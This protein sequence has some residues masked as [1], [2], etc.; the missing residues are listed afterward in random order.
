MGW[1]HNFRFPQGF[2]GVTMAYGGRRGGGSYRSCGG[3]FKPGIPD[4][5]DF[6]PMQR[7]RFPSFLL[8]DVAVSSIT[9]DIVSAGGSG[10][11]T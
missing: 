8:V 2:R 11:D 6:S 7:H 10:D 1:L 9:Y 4:F 3:F 5:S